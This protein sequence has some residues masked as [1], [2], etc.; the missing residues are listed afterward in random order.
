MNA[1]ANRNEA[2]GNDETYHLEIFGQ[3]LNL[4]NFQRSIFAPT[5]GKIAIANDSY[6]IISDGVRMDGV[7][8]TNSDVHD[9]NTLIEFSEH[10]GK[11]TALIWISDTKI[12]VGYDTG[13]VACF[14]AVGNLL[15][16]R[17]FA[18]SAVQAMR[19]SDEGSTL[20]SVRCLWIMYARGRL[21]SVGEVIAF[22]PDDKNDGL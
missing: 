22:I 11:P 9:V 18:S 17:K 1:V 2:P 8:A 14:D 4:N 21:I 16:E 10:S 20:N 5:R 3:F 15:F 19:I 13:T 7:P 12:C 6:L